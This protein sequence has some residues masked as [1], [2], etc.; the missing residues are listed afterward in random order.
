MISRWLPSSPTSKHHSSDAVFRPVFLSSFIP[1]IPLRFPF[2]LLLSLPIFLLGHCLDRDAE[3]QPR[4]TLSLVDQRRL[5]SWSRHWNQQPNHLASRHADRLPQT[6][7]HAAASHHPR[8]RT[9]P[10]SVACGAKP[11]HLRLAH[12]HSWSTAV[13]ITPPCVT[14]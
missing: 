14:T 7:H 1:I 10:H 2:F 11:G 13:D 12:L 3:S 6:L 9:N 5:T 4:A 8:A